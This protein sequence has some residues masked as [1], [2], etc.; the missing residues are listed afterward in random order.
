[1]EIFN[2]TRA[3]DVPQAIEIAAQS[4]HRAAGSAVRFIAGGTTLST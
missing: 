4:E 3:A 2:Y 1:M